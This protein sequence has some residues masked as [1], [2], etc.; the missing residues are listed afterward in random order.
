M[1]R[2]NNS[3]EKN[4]SRIIIILLSIVIVAC[5]DDNIIFEDYKKIYTKEGWHKDSSMTF[6]INVK[7]ISNVYDIL[8]NIRN[9]NDYEFSNLYLFCYISKNNDIIKSDTLEYLMADLNGRWLGSGVGY[10]KDNCLSYLQFYNFKDT[11]SY[12]ISIKQGMRKIFLEGINNVGIKI[13]KK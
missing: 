8:I 2:K 3:S 13:E 7:D 6:D 1:P 5:H 12:K 11:G 10:I 4:M 9:D